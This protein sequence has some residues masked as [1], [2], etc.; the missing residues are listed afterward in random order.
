MVYVP[1]GVPE[2]CL[3]SISHSRLTGYRNELGTRS[4]DKSVVLV[5]HHGFAEKDGTS[6]F[7]AL[8]CGSE[9]ASFER[10]QI[11]N[12]KIDGGGVIFREDLRDGGNGTR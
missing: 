9:P 4:A 5:D 6:R 1:M 11:G 2:K 10:L 3:Q 8:T 12:L 7:Q